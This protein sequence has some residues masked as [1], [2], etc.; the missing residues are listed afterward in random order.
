MSKNNMQPAETDWCMIEIFQNL[1]KDSMCLRT[2]RV[3]LAR[4]DT[5]GAH[6]FCRKV[7]KRLLLSPTRFFEWIEKEGK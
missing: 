6:H 5:N 4:R 3:I 1:I 2:L 7:G